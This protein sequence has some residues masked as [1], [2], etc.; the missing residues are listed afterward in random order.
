MDGASWP[1]FEARAQM[2]DM[3]M[4]TAEEAIGHFPWPRMGDVKGGKQPNRLP[5]Y[6]LRCRCYAQPITIRSDSN[7]I[8]KDIQDLKF[9]VAGLLGASNT[10][11]DRYVEG[12]GSKTEKA[13]D[14]A[15]VSRNLK[16]LQSAQSSYEGSL[17]AAGLIGWGI[18]KYL[19][20]KKPVDYI[21][22]KSAFDVHVVSKDMEFRRSAAQSKRLSKFS[23]DAA[24]DP[25]TMVLVEGEPMSY[26]VYLRDGFDTFDFEDMESLGWAYREDGQDFIDED[27]LDRF[28]SMIGE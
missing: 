19:D 12:C 9:R 28:H 10:R 24:L 2:F 15:C 13:M 20:R 18:L 26:E 23:K 27:I 5:P 4:M 22:D 8:P 3:L 14:G 6:H 16:E 1:L 21:T 25:W 7:L 17:L 11:V